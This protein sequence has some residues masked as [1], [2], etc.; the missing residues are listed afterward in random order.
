MTTPA[1]AKARIAFYAPLKPPDHSIASGD[2]QM[3][4]MLM[5]ALRRAGYD[6]FLASRYIAYSKRYGAEHLAERK[7]GALAEA[8]RLLAEWKKTSARP[9]LWFCYHP[10]DKSPDWIGPEIAKRLRIPIVNAE[11]C[12]TGQG[13]NGEWL[14]WR[15]EAQLS[16]L[17]A[18]L[19][20]VMTESDRNYLA[21]FAPRQRVETLLPF[22]D[23]DLL[24]PDAEIATGWP[25]PGCRLLTVGMMRPG[26]KLDSYRVLSRSLQS[27][28]TRDWSL[29]V[30]GDGPEM[31]TIRE[32][33]GFAGDSVA[34][35][36]QC[37]PGQVLALMRQAD[38]LAWPGCREAYGMVYLE[39]AAMGT[40]ALALANLGVPLVVE[41]GRTGL[42]AD[43]E[44]TGDYA[45]KLARMIDDDELRRRLATGAR[46]FVTGER[47][48]EQAARKLRAMIDRLLAEWN[49]GNG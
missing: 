41:D 37:E 30:C 9:D 31:A 4:R 23:L 12:K 24:V 13:P 3:A 48:G 32:W 47:S 38:I 46:E 45:G 2:R 29:L 25:S 7:A 11:P 5:A 21:T 17:A 8:E 10:Y 19:N 28:A 15:A 16:I 40:P 49:A 34:F 36:G 27:M 1:K 35:L 26:A 42:L 14:P 18:A 20:I 39:A 43:P 6:T 22:V 33:F 44:T